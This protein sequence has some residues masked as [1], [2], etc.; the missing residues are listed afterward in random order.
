[1]FR[2]FPSRT[3]GKPSFYKGGLLTLGTDPPYEM[4]V[5]VIRFLR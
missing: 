5:P 1:M 3:M 4:I 2:Y